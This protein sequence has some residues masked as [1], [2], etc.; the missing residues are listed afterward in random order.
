MT[1]IPASLVNAE[2]K[3]A[4]TDFIVEVI[5]GSAWYTH[6]LR[7][8]QRQRVAYIVLNSLLLLI[9]PPAIVLLKNIG[10]AAG[11][12]VGQLMAVLTG[13]L[14]LQKT[15][16]GFFSAQQRYAVWWKTG[17]DLKKLWYGLLA[18]WKGKVTSDDA[19]IKFLADVGAKTTQARQQIGDEEYDFFQKLTLPSFDILDILTKTGSAVG[20][21]H[22]DTPWL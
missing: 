7:T 9:I 17:A 21:R 4:L 18:D 16:S 13:V 14:A 5:L 19:R 22:N 1:G 3:T 15:L 8:A 11:S 10:G 12:I 6:K 2:L 20:S